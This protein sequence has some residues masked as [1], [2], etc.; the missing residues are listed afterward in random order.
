VLPLQLLISGIGIGTMYAIVALGFTLVWNASGTVNFAQGQLVMMGAYLAYSILELGHLPYAIAIP[1]TIVGSFVLGV[2]L[3]RLT[4]RPVRRPDAL[5]IIIITI[6]TGLALQAFAQNIWGPQP[7]TIPG[8]SSRDDVH[9]GSVS[10]TTQ[11]LWDIGIGVLLMVLLGLLLQRTYLGRAMRAVAQDGDTARQLGIPA[12]LVVSF[13]F[14]LNAALAGVAGL[15]LAPTLFI[16]PNMGI[17]VTLQAFAA[18]VLGGFGSILGAVIGGLVLGL[19][20]VYAAAYLSG[21]YADAAALVVLILVLI[22]RPRGLL[23]TAW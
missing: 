7:R 4:I 16:S 13:T 2:L 17:T 22:V 14:G 10:I 19:T 8:L 3:E 5:I 12:P 6:G 20:Q 18:A 15:L 11:A 21:S 23:R 9:V 1:G